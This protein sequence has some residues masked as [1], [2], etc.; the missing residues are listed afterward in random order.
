VTRLP[1]FACGALA[2]A[3][4][5]TSMT[6][7]PDAQALTVDAPRRDLGAVRLGTEVPLAF[8][9]RNPTARPVRVL[10]LAGG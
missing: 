6:R 1:A 8:R 4:A 2:F 5:G 9:F 10:G 3:L 7:P